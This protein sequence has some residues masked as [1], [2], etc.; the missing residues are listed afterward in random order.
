MRTTLL[1]TLTLMLAYFLIL[2]GGVAFIQ[3]KRFFGSAPKE[4]L[5][6]IPDRNERFPCCNGKNDW[7]SVPNP[8]RN[9]SFL[10][11]FEASP[12]GR[13]SS[14]RIFHKK[15]RMLRL[16]NLSEDEPHARFFVFNRSLYPADCAAR[17]ARTRRAAAERRALSA[18]RRTGI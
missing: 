4:N 1:A 15:T 18:V 2:Y 8:A 12:N 3:D 6:A 5:A 14:P 9:P 16:S 17:R 10:P 11:G 13:P 7:D